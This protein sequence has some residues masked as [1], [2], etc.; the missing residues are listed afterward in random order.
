[1]IQFQS[2]REELQSSLEKI[3]REN[4]HALLSEQEIMKDISN[5]IQLS[6]T[7]QSQ[8]RDKFNHLLAQ[9]KQQRSN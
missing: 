7:Q 9:N 4:S 8:A 3:N 5:V 2:P 1:M 6:N